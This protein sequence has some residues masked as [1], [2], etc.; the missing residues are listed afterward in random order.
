MSEDPCEGFW[1]NPR[2]KRFAKSRNQPWIWRGRLVLA[3][4]LVASDVPKSHLE[5]P[6]TFFLAA[7]QLFERLY[8]LWTYRYITWWWEKVLAYTVLSSL[9]VAKVSPD[10]W[11]ATELTSEVWPHNIWVQPGILERNMILTF[12]F[13]TF[14]DHKT[15][16]L[17]VK[18]G[19]I[20][21]W[22][23]AHFI[24]KYGASW[25]FLSEISSFVCCFSNNGT[26]SPR[27]WRSYQHCRW[28]RLP[29]R[30]GGETSHQ[31]HRCDP[32]Q[33]QYLFFVQE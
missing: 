29:P 23:Y 5:W 18:L 3:K 22:C 13:L 16:L 6:I 21:F 27:A 1:Q 17:G 7:I 30:S 24:V 31:H 15:T 28:Q 2:R 9:Q 26:S 8:I 20:Y 4:L 12:E 25:I 19:I 14:C 32:K 33:Q 11:K 10:G